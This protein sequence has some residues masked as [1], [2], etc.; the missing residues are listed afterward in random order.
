MMTTQVSY[1]E[2]NK[3]HYHLLLIGI[4]VIA[5]GFLDFLAFWYNLNIISPLFIGN[6]FST[7]ERNFYMFSIFVSGYLSRPL[8][9]A[10]MGYY[11]DKY[12][13]KP[14]LMYSVLAVSLCTLIIGLLP[15]YYY[16]G[17][18]ATL[19]F[20]IARLAQGMA[21]GSQMPLVWIYISE[22]FPLNNTGFASGI[23]TAGCAVGALVLVGLM[24]S[25]DH[26]LTQTQMIQYGWR[27]PFILG[28]LLGL[29]VYVF[30][31]SL[32]ESQLFLAHKRQQ[33]PQNTKP[34]L[35]LISQQKQQWQG[36]FS[37]MTLSW[38]VASLITIIFFILEELI[39]ITFFIDDT[40]LSVAFVACLLFLVMGCV[41]F[42][43]LSDRSNTAKIFA[44]ASILFIIA[45][46]VLFYDLQIN[47]TFIIFSLALFGFCA[48]IIG[49]IPTL[50]ARVCPI[51]YRLSTISIGYNMVYMVVGIIT[52]TLLG[53]F[54]YYTDFAPALYLSFLGMLMLFL[55]FYLYYIPK[56]NIASLPNF[57][58]DNQ[59]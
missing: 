37:I 47:G 16:A 41:F 48:G 7:E 46:M 12:G 56:E 49:I 6:D 1:P 52:P 24:H 20:I 4:L 32:E 3:S 42:G 53:F 30:A 19:F 15:T 58:Y 5:I 21:F 9:A 34:F 17:I 14:V 59:T 57:E 39:K 50:I 11:G 10:I 40:L 27:I 31:K 28:G 23:A 26:S 2:L 25:L 44:I 33:K 8:G 43:F 51:D 29:M 35:K 13:R 18:T 38:F 55:S 54:T 22:H 45:T 36:I